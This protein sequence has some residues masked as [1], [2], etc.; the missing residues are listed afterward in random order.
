MNLEW[1]AS[2]GHCLFLFSY[3]VEDIQASWREVVIVAGTRRA[4]NALPYLRHMIKIPFLSVFALAL[5]NQN[6][7]TAM[8]QIGKVVAQAGLAQIE[9][10]PSLLWLSKN[11]TLTYPRVPGT[12]HHHRTYIIFSSLKPQAGDPLQRPVR[13][14]P[15]IEGYWI[16]KH[17]NSEQT[18]TCVFK[19]LYRR[20]W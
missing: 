2:V 12:G 7:T 19:L 15:V 8:V 6:T 13:P 5:P 10:L 16:T 9:I 20:L 17:V 14:V 3:T 11:L 1:V 4:P 18:A